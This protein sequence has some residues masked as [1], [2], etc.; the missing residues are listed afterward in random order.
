MKGMHDEH[1]SAR[2]V[3]KFQCGYG[4]WSPAGRHHYKKGRY[5]AKPRTT[6]RVVALFF[7]ILVN[8]KRAD[9]RGVGHMGST[10]GLEI[11]YPPAPM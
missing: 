1:G 4:S 7:S 3:S 9:F 5:F 2:A 10:V 11:D 6:R 8:D